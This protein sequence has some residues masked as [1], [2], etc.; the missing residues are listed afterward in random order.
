MHVW[1]KCIEALA[2]HYFLDWPLHQ[3]ESAG[4]SSSQSRSLQ[5]IC[6]ARTQFPECMCFANPTDY[7]GSRDMLKA[8]LK[9]TKIFNEDINN[10]NDDNNHHNKSNG[11]H[12]FPANKKEGKFHKVSVMLLLS[13]LSDTCAMSSRLPHSHF[14]HE[15]IVVGLLLRL[16]Y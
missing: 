2:L 1:S 14:V 4:V 15:K 11:C 9:T 13:F 7:L 12:P 3:F 5:L 6:Q 8:S 16:S 10:D